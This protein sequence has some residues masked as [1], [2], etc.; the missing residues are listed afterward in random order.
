MPRHRIELD[1]AAIQEA[2]AAYRW[3]AE[4]SGSAAAGL[5]Q[6]IEA[7]IDAIRESPARWSQYVHGTRRFL[8]RRFPFMI[9]YRELGD[10]VQVVAVAHAKRRPGYWKAR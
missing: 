4:R 8:L 7:A 3:Y 1:P 6:E 9:V 2:Q 5:E 10:V